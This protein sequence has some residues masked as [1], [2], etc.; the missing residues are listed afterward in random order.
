MSAGEKQIDCL[1]YFPSLD[2]VLSPGTINSTSNPM[3]MMRALHA[4]FGAMHFTLEETVRA[5]VF[6]FA[7]PFRKWSRAISN[8][9]VRCSSYLRVQRP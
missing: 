1:G 7:V 8:D 2:K 5:A 9:R 6:L 3:T 4:K